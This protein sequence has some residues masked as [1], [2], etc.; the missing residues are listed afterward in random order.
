MLKLAAKYSL[1]T[2]D[3]DP[4]NFWLGAVGL[5][6][7]GAIVWSR[8]G[9]PYSSSVDDYRIIQESHAEGRVLRKLGKGGTIFVSRVSKKTRQLAMAR[10]CSYCQAAI[11]AREVKKVIYSI[12]ELQY[13]VWDIVNDLDK[14]YTLTEEI[15]LNF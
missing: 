6:K 7:D 14:V 12:N 3:S 1:P 8:N 9:A 2:M 15:Q 13:G 4:R 11:N 10:P 5:R